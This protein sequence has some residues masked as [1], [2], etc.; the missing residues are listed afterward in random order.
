MKRER[1]LLWRVIFFVGIFGL[2]QSA[3]VGAKDGWLEHLVIQQ[4]TVPSAAWLISLVSPSVGVQPVGSRLIAPGGGINILNGCEGMDTVFLIVSAMLVAP[5]SSWRTRLLGLLCGTLF[6]M[7]L[8]QARVL[9]LF[10]AFR[11]DRWMFDMLHGLI[12]PLLLVMAASAFFIAWL[13]KFAH[14]APAHDGQRLDP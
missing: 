9:A 14:V 12:G 5:L 11:S 2:L 3:Y 7:L 8:N 1:G 6:I 4:I 13:Q 10:Y